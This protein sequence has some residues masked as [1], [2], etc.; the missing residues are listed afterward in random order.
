VATSWAN[1]ARNVLEY[2]DGVGRRGNSAALSG[3]ELGVAG[4]RQ[5]LIPK[6][7][8]VIRSQGIGWGMVVEPSILWRAA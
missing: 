4:A 8:V 3:S 1:L 5:R 7:A 2:L 6:R